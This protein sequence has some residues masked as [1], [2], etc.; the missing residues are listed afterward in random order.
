[1]NNKAFTIIELIITIVLIGIVVIP[2]SI[3]LV[4]SIRGAFKSQDIM[5]AV[6]LARMAL[7]TVNNLPYDHNYLRPTTGRVF[8]NY[9]G[10]GYD[11]RVIINQFGSSPERIKEIR[12]EVYPTGK[13]GDPQE[14]STTV[15]TGR[16]ENVQY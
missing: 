6:N 8:S 1:M 13:V 11:L 14:L 3:F 2:S 10:Y 16:A 7:E 4:E 12:V 15:I 5:V 9:E